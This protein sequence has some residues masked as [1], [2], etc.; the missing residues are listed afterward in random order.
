MER[1][2]PIQIKPIWCA[3]LAAARSRFL[4]RSSFPRTLPFILAT[5]RLSIGFSL[6]GVISGEFLSSTAGLGYLVDSTSKSYQMS[7]TLGGIVAIAIIAALE[8]R[9]LCASRVV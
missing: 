9:C 8:C 4:P 3:P 7:E 2:A 6:L 1:A 5:L